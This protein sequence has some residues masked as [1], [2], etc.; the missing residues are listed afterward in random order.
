MLPTATARA[1][2]TTYQPKPTV[3]RNNNAFSKESAIVKPINLL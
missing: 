3:Q 2:T 1:K